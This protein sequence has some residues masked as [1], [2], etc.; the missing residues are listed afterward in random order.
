MGADLINRNPQPGV[1]D[2]LTAIQRS[3]Q[4][5][6]ELRRIHA[7]KRC[8]TGLLRVLNHALMNAAINAWNA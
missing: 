3:M 1:S 8:S 5:T 7:I 6:A 2:H 4:N